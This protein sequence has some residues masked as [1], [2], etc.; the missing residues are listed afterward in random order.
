M[1]TYICDYAAIDPPTLVGAVEYAF[2]A[3]T[4]VWEHIDDEC[5]E[6]TVYDA[7]DRLDEIIEPYLYTHPADWD[8]CDY[9]CGFDP[10]MGCYTDDC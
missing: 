5:F 2:P 3:A 1:K 9:E 10:Y 7:D 4:A 6:F 8:D